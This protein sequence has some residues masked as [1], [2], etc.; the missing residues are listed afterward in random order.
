MDLYWAWVLGMFILAAL[1]FYPWKKS[2]KN[3]GEPLFVTKAGQC[4]NPYCKDTL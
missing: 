2:C 1:A 3:C 4:Y